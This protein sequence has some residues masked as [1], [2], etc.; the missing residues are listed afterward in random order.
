MASPTPQ[1]DL[2]RSAERTGWT[3]IRGTTIC[4]ERFSADFGTEEWF[5]LNI[6]PRDGDDVHR[7]YFLR[8]GAMARTIDSLAT[9]AAG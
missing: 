2:R 7:T 4:T 3:H 8:H 9:R 6:V 5:G 1:E